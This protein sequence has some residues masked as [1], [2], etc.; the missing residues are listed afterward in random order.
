MKKITQQDL[1]SIFAAAVRTGV[2]L[3]IRG[4]R[5]FAILKRQVRKR[6]EGKVKRIV[7]GLAFRGRKYT[8]YIRVYE[9]EKS[10]RREVEFEL[11]PS[12]LK[13]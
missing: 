13:H 7:F 3:R 8:L 10:T 4:V 6:D 12:E 5:G 2:K 11:R 1:E 9:E